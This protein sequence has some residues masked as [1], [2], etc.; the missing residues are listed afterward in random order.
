VIKYICNGAKEYYGT[1]FRA[2]HNWNH[3]QEVVSNLRDPSQSLLIAAHWHDAV[4]WPGAGSDANERCSASA[5]DYFIHSLSD[6]IP[7]SLSEI[8]CKAKQLILYTT[9]EVHFHDRR[10]G[11]DLAQLLDADLSAL[12]KP[13]DEFVLNQAKILAENNTSLEES[14]EACQSF[15]EKF[16]TTRNFIYHTDYYRLNKETIARENIERFCAE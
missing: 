11:G 10:I 3:A 14:K 8:I 1:P 9:I 2:Y 16:L 6:T 15:L 7:D 12:A 5:L 4:Y 13:Y